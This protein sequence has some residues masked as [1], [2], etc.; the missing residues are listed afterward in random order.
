METRLRF[1]DRLDGVSKY[2]TWKERIMLVLMENEIWEFFNTHITPPTNVTEL[3]IHNQ[4]DSEPKCIILD[5]VKD[6]LIPHLSRKTTNMDM[7]E[8]LKGLFQIKNEIHKMVLREKLKDT[9]MT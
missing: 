6:H 4:K 3:T 1:E 2:N 8:S 9:K 5:G 7:R